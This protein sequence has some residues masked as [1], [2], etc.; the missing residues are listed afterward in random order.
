MLIYGSHD[1][2]V[3]RIF[4]NSEDRQ[5]FVPKKQDK[6]ENSDDIDLDGDD[7]I[8][9]DAEKLEEIKHRRLKA[10]LDGSE[11]WHKDNFDE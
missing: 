9:I 4:F 1:G 8:A 2:I 10:M 7:D 6:D 5:F 11:T 3:R